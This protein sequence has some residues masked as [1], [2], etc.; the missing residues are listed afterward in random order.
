M[1][2]ERLNF[3]RANPTDLQAIYGGGCPM[4][5]QFNQLLRELDAARERMLLARRDGE[6]APDIM[7]LR[8]RSYD[9]WLAAE[10]YRQRTGCSP[11]PV[12]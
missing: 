8:A 10:S 6:A 5:A 1:G 12:F 4:D 7:T 2:Q 9:A 11:N 3:F